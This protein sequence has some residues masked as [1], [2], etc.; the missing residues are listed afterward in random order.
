MK[1]RHLYLPRHQQ[2]LT[3]IS[4]ILQTVPQNHLQHDVCLKAIFII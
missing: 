3:G 1:I 2:E 4:T